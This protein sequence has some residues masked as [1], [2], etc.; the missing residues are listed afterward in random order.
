[1]SKRVE[2][3]REMRMRDEILRKMRRREERVYNTAIIVILALTALYFCW[4]GWMKARQPDL[5][6]A[7]YLE[8]RY[9]LD[10]DTVISQPHRW[11]RRIAE[12]PE[13]K[14]P[15]HGAVRKG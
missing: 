2:E 6:R 1:M 3:V 8:G 11:A 4:L 15:P 10:H 7:A 12:T 9:G 14:D 13:A 5:E